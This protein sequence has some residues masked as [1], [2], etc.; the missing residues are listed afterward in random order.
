VAEETEIVIR[1][2]RERGRGRGREVFF[3]EGDLASRLLAVRG[4]LVESWAHF[5]V[6]RRPL[7]GGQSNALCIERESAVSIIRTPQSDFC[8][9]GKS[10]LGL[11]DRQL[12]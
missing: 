7:L 11:E 6:R 3:K 5:L 4:F 10:K 2:A 1:R 8:V 9:T 12:T